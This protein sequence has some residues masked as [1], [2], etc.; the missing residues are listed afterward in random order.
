MKIDIA[1]LPALVSQPERSVAVV[2]DVLRAT[3]SAAVLL[4]RGVPAVYVAASISDAAA[5]RHE[6]GDGVLLCGERDGVAPEGFDHGN[7][8]LEF[9]DMALPSPPP[10]VVLATTNG[11]KAL[12]AASPSPV[13][14][15]G[16]LVNA[17]AVVDAVL[18]EA[19]A[20]E[21]DVTFICSGTAGRFSLDDAYTAGV[22]AARLTLAAEHA[23]LPVERTDAV[24]AALAI[25]RSHGWK[26]GQALRESAHGRFLQSIGM[27]NDVIV[28]A[29]L[30]RFEVAPRLVVDDH[31]RLVVSP[32]LTPYP[33]SV[34]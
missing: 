26:A 4:S 34:L 11:T 10:S 3:T 29:Q 8:P 5:L 14:F 31:P 25:G 12:L 15:A 16:A 17:G 20:R 9:A 6:I 23:G 32:G 2:I 21:L 7:S 24:H 33:D 18:A 1:L 30:D 19:M 27:E 13:V 28:C 22:L